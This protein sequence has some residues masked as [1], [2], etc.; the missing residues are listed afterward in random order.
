MK[1]TLLAG[2]GL[3]L[4][5]LTWAGCASSGGS[6]DTSAAAPAKGAKVLDIAVLPEG[7]YV[8]E[9]AR[10]DAMTL[11]RQ[12]YD[13]MSDTPVRIVDA[14]GGNAEALEQLTILLEQK[15]ITPVE[16]VEMP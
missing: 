7:D 9:N 2:V 6:A 15:G 8:M 11:R 12:L 1:M 4:G 5:L 13:M 14:S 10:M 3:A 16:I